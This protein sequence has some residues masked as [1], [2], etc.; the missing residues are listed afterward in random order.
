MRI[1]LHSGQTLCRKVPVSRGSLAAPLSDRDLEKKLRELAE[2]GG[3]RL[4]GRAVA[5]CP[6]V[7]GS[8]GGCK[9]GHA[10]RRGWMNV[11]LP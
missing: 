11:D 5:R 6:V 1:F 4:C 9:R 8:G 2:Y 10:T 3:V 7:T